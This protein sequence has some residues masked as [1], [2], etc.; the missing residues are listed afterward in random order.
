VG[1]D[2]CSHHFLDQG[3]RIPGRKRSAGEFLGKRTA[4]TVLQGHVWLTLQRPEIVNLND[5][6]VGQR[7]DPLGF[8][9][10]PVS[11]DPARMPTGQD[12]FQGHDPI[13]AD[14]PGLV[15]RTHPTAFDE[16]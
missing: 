13:Q 6:R 8:P 15:H 2:H 7:S 11:L 14:L 10:E 3:S 12:H 4:P 5:P 9:D 1:R 16:P